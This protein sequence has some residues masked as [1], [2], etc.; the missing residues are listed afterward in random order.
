MNLGLP[1]QLQDRPPDAMAEFRRALKI[2]PTLAGA[3]FFLGRH[4]KA[5]YSRIPP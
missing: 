3:N 1:Y 5:N 4:R 2:K